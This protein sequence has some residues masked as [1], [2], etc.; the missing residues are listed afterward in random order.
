MLKYFQYLYIILGIPLSIK[1]ESASEEETMMRENNK[2]QHK[3]LLRQRTNA[4]NG[5]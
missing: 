1:K 2:N 5:K 3:M 4:I